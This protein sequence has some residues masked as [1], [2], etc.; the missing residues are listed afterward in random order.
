MA[1]KLENTMKNIQASRPK[2]AE[3]LGDAFM[4]AVDIADTKIDRSD[5]K[6]RPASKKSLK[7]NDHTPTK[8][9]APSQKQS[10]MGGTFMSNNLT[11]PLSGDESS[12]MKSSVMKMDDT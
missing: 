7:T 11:S 8:S 12:V 5:I 4:T 1:K 2:P 3:K 9:R 10:I 6:T